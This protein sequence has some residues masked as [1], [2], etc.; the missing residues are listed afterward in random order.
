ML[1]VEVNHYSYIIDTYFLCRQLHV[2]D[3]TYVMNQVKE[4][5]CYVALDFNKEIEMAK[6]RWPEN[7]IIRDYILPDYTSIRRGYVRPL[8]LAGEGEHVI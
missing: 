7:T 6:K 1:F 5:S 8:D 2:M 3:E 4:D